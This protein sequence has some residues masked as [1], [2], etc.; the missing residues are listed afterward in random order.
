MGCPCDGEKPLG[1][2]DQ[3][4]FLRAVLFGDPSPTR[5]PP[6]SYLLLG[7]QTRLTQQNLCHFVAFVLLPL[8][9]LLLLCYLLLDN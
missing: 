1:L 6:V 5:P 7:R 4:A 8:T 9:G 3:A 2:I